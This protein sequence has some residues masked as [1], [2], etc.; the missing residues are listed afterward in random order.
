MSAIG[1]DYGFERVFERQL[2]GLGRRGDV[3]L[4]LSTS[5]RSPN[6]LVALKTARECGLVTIGFTG[7]Q[8]GALRTLCDIC[9]VAPCEE[10]ALIQQIYMTA[11]HVIC[12][13]VERD[14][15]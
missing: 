3:F 6:V 15:G 2:R 4:A 7:T 14:L 1:N 9:L 11:A 5:G 10:T 8:G 12:A 13:L